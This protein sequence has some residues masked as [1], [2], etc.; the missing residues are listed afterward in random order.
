MLTRRLALAACLGLL[1]AARALAQPLG[2]PALPPPGEIPPPAPGIAP[3]PRLPRPPVYDDEDDG[4]SERAAIRIARRRG[5]VAVDRVRRGRNVW[6]VAGTDE[7][8]DEIRVIVN[9][10]GEIVDVR[11]D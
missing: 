11:R 5:V 6:I 1:P 8:G 4:I 9:D 7:Y 2:G 10:E 3:P